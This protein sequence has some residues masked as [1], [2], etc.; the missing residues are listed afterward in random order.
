MKSWYFF[1]FQTAELNKIDKSA[2]EPNF[3]NLL[4]R[5]T[6]NTDSNPSWIFN[7]DSVV[8]IWTGCSRQFSDSS[9]SL[10]SV[11]DFL[12]IEQQQIIQLFDIYTS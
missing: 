4:G 2:Q 1:P 11:P 12:L 6:D 10:V 7:F 5:W 9:N 8:Q 3:I